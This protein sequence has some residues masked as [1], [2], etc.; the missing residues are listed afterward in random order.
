LDNDR[1]VKVNKGLLQGSTLSPFLFNLFINELASGLIDIVGNQD[2]VHFYA[3]DILV[4]SASKD[5]TAKVLKK[6][7]EWTN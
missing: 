3:D 2:N 7:E 5:E 6:I 4:L 1:I